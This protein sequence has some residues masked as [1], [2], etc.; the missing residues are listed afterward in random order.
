MISNEISPLL[1]NDHSNSA[2]T[3]KNADSSAASHRVYRLPWE[4]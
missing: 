3:V 4:N 2:L 1:K